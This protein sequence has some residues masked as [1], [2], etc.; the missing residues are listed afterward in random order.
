ME[1]SLEVFIISWVL[2]YRLPCTQPAALPWGFVS[3][4]LP[5]LLRVTLD[6][7]P[8]MSTGPVLKSKYRRQSHA[9]L[10][11]RE[12]VLNTALALLVSVVLADS[13]ATRDG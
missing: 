6:V 13:G 2:R 3:W 9:L 5:I 11:S 10:L 1:N 12:R 4:L 8:D 7:Q